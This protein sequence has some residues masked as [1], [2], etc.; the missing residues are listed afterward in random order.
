MQAKAKQII[1]FIFGTAQFS[2]EVWILNTQTITY[3]SAITSLGRSEYSKK[4]IGYGKEE[5]I[6][7]KFKSF[8]LL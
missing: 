5:I 4:T 1:I 6:L 3:P 2:L 8:I 7:N